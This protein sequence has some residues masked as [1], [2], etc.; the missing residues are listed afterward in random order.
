MNFARSSSRALVRASV[1]SMAPIQQ[2]K[3]TAFIEI[4]S[5]HMSTA[6]FVA[7]TSALCYTFPKVDQ[8]K[9]SYL[10]S[11]DLIPVY[12]AQEEKRNIAQLSKQLDSTASKWDKLPSAGNFRSVSTRL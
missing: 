12:L 3:R 4:A 7:L 1:A 10:N 11:A 2:Q 6:L 8:E 5:T 9:F